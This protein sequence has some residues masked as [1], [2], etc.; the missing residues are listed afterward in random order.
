MWKQHNPSN[1]SFSNIRLARLGNGPNCWSH[2]SF[3]LRGG[4]GL[5]NELTGF[6][7]ELPVETLME[8]P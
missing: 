1:F 5:N 3:A 7:V 6:P 4:C 8:H 2:N